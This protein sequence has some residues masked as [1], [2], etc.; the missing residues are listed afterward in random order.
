MQLYSFIS[1]I[2]GT[3]VAPCEIYIKKGK[4]YIDKTTKEKRGKQLK[5]KLFYHLC[6]LFAIK[7]LKR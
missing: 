2:V 5:S 6:K 1:Y 7:Q 3:S 4:K